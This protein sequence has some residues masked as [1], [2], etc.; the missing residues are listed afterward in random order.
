MREAGT[1]LW[2][3]PRPEHGGKIEYILKSSSTTSSRKYRVAY[4]AK[5]GE[6]FRSDYRYTIQPVTELSVAELET[7]I[8]TA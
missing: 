7:L 1:W 3:Q 2:P 8:P 6:A 5:T 4:S